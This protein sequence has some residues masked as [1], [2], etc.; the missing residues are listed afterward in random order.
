MVVRRHYEEE[1]IGSAQEPRKRDFPLEATAFW[2]NFLEGPS[3][4]GF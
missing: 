3:G 2:R 1:K 4:P